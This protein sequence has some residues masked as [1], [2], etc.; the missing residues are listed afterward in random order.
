VGTISSSVGLIFIIWE[1]EM[2]K[3]KTFIGIAAFSL[4]VLALPSVASAQ[5]GGYGRNDDYYG[6]NRYNRNLQATARNLKNRARNFVGTT[7][8]GATGGTE[9]MVI[10]TPAV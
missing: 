10:I 8:G 1:K 6:N 5:W 7:I 2:N 3:V 9:A 4:V